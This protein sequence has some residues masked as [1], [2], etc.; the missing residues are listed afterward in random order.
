MIVGLAL[1]AGTA[2]T[3]CSTVSTGASEVALQY[4][5]GPFDS[6]AYVSC[7]GGST[8]ERNDVNDDHYYYP[9][10][11]RD[12][13]FGGDGNGKDA[14]G[15]TSTSKDGQ[16]I[17]ISGTVKI[18]MQLSCQEFTDPTGKKWP[19]GTAQFFHEKIG[20]KDP[21]K[22]AYNTDG[23][24][25]Y[26]E[27]WSRML[28]EYLGFAVNDALDNETTSF[29]LDELTLKADQKNTW[30]AA[31]KNGLPKTLKELTFDVEVFRVE[32]V[33]LEKPGVRADIADARAAKIAAQ[34]QV[35]ASNVIA[36]RAKTWPGGLAAYQEFLREQAVNRAIESGKIKAVPVPYGSPVIVPQN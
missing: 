31:V 33:L 19:G 14:A 3:A 30:Q 23:S 27:G 20:S 2:A 17:G 6:R 11:Q 8:L 4:A 15:I 12:F 21:S 29:T 7:F 5:A 28:A 36:E 24:S 22:P 13:S 26:G 9:T 1:L 35:N 25:S 34:E 18:T 16:E 10:G 32:S